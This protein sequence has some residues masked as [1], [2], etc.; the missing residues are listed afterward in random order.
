MKKRWLKL[1]L[2]SF[3]ITFSVLTLSGT[4]Y[5]VSATLLTDP[6][7]ESIRKG[8]EALADDRLD[9]A[10]KY[11]KKALKSNETSTDGRVGLADVYVKKGDVGKAVDVLKEGISLSLGVYEYY[12]KIISIYTQNN[13][14]AEARS[15]INAVSNQFVSRKLRENMPASVTA[16]P[17]PGQ[18]DK[19]ISVKLS[20]SEGAKIYYT[21]DGSQPTLQSTLYDGNS[22][23]VK[24]T[25]TL[26]AFAVNDK[27][28]LSE[29]ELN[30]SYIVV[31][32]NKKYTFVDPK[33]EAIV[34]AALN[35]PTGDIT[36]KQILSIRKFTNIDAAGNPFEG[37]ITSLDDITQMKNLSEL[38]LAGEQMIADYSG[39]SSLPVLRT[40]T[41]RGCGI[42]DT[43]F[44]A[45]A[46]NTMLIS[47]NLSQ[48]T[49]SDITQISGMNNLSY[50]SLSNNMIAD[51]TPLSA[52]TSLKTLDI[53]KNL[54][55]DISALSSL[56]HLNELLADS[57]QIT[58]FSPLRPLSS[59][60]RLD[61][62]DN[63]IA[64]LPDMATFAALSEL[65][66]SG[67]IVANLMPLAVCSSLDS[68][69]I[70]R[71]AVYDLAPLSNLGLTRLIAADN[72]ILS[73]V[74]AASMRQL[75]VLDVSRNYLSDI[76]PLSSL[77]QLES[78]YIGGND[79][80]DVSDLGSISSLRE[81]YCSSIPADDFSAINTH[82]VRVYR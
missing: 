8:Q 21:T 77:P 41:L 80:W 19:A 15:F 25:I 28:I 69:D 42:S 33:V 76:S 67:N 7:G 13:M 4:I 74:P 14:I 59:L 75:R 20:S 72:Q 26:R 5:Y 50:L 32:T 6:A 37:A 27:M 23:S 36:Y 49:I 62:S 51:F 78:V 52:L 61:L 60:T 3:I 68:L 40:L 38:T 47:L 48:N 31:Q 66:L 9:D 79:I 65:D 39:L 1:F 44:K 55:A 58:D 17:E 12:E 30:A 11:F 24:E 2:Y 71:N 34:R 64:A 16:S 70:S 81:I 53:S 45:I 73:V 35:M 22:I 56:T 54:A 57:N 63:Q 18:Y 43:S 29:T 46:A 10:E 82:V